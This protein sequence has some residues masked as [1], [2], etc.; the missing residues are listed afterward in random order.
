MRDPARLQLQNFRRVLL[1]NHL[2]FDGRQPQAVDKLARPFHEVRAADEVV[3]TEDNMVDSDQFA[4]AVE[5]PAIPSHRGI[6]IKLA[7]RLARLADRLLIIAEEAGLIERNIDPP[8]E[9]RKRATQMCANLLNKQLNGNRDPEDL[10]SHIENEP[11]VKRA[12]D[13]GTRPNGQPR[14][15]PP[16]S[17]R[18]LIQAFQQWIAQARRVHLVNKAVSVGVLRPEPLT[19]QL[20]S[21]VA[22]LQLSP[23][24]TF[25][26]QII[27]RKGR[28]STVSASNHSASVT[29]GLYGLAEP[30]GNNFRMF[31]IVNS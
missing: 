20:G 24:H 9:I 17:H 11:L 10:L 5:C 19:G 12:Y 27:A 16:I 13:P 31:Y 26:N 2:A 14:T 22:G 18:A 21:L 23:H 25:G 3:R 7:H 15:T 28:K 1:V 4:R 8:R 6:H 30:V 29:H